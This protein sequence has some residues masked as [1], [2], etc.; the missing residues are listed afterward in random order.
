MEETRYR[1]VASECLYKDL[2]I[3]QQ[4]RAVTPPLFSHAHV[5]SGDGQ[6]RFIIIIYHSIT[7]HRFQ[8]VAQS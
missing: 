6:Q 8:N 4:P 5:S 2:G 1:Q 7:D 3:Q